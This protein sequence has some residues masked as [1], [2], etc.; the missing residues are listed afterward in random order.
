MK[1]EKKT[2]TRIFVGVAFC[3]IL[4]WILN[5]TERVKNVIAVI[6]G[7]L[8]PFAIGAA[9][10]FIL[11]VPMRFFEK[12]LN[13]MDN[14][15][16]R[17]TIALVITFAAIILVL[18]LVFNLLIPQITLTVQAL[19]PKI[20]NFAKV[21]ETNIMAFLQDNPDLKQWIFGS[22]ALKELNLSSVIQQAVTMITNSVTTIAGGVV[23][24]VGSISGALVDAVLGIVFG[25]YCLFRK[26]ILARQ[27]RRILYSFVP[28][29]IADNIVRILRLTNL[30]FSNF[31]SGQCLEAV[32]LGGLFAFAMAIFRM[33]YIPLISV[34]IAITALIPIVGAFVGCILGAFFI[35]VD[36]P[37]LAVWF[38]VMFLVIQQFEGNLIYPRV[39]GTSIG[40]PGMWVLMAVAVGGDMMGITGML[41]MI[42]LASVIYTLAREVTD[43]MLEKK[44][45]PIE[46]LQ[47]HPNEI[48]QGFKEKRE[49][50]KMMSNIK[51]LNIPAFIRK[52]PVKPAVKNQDEQSERTEETK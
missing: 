24:A 23:S 22:G 4:Y 6:S 15:G 20:V 14:V 44:N 3:I 40:L 19:V 11:N 49:H 31:I 2:L 41:I 48:P 52:H 18:V 30:T 33:P 21:V 16:M 42:P 45:I 1:I 47:D 29:G 46:K 17:R 32:I 39:V 51:I 10:A 8:S 12:K 35:L 38:V 43:Y 5:E 34:L 25:I 9:L 36:S 26:E 50:S 28:E 13:F 37:I 7:I 27:G